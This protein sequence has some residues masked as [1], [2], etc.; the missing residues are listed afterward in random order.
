MCGRFPCIISDIL[1]ITW[2]L[3]YEGIDQD[4]QRV[5]NFKDEYMHH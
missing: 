5:L 1:G 3:G 4:E 2:I